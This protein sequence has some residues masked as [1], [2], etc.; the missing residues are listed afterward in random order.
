MGMTC[1]LELE[2]NTEREP[3]HHVCTSSSTSVE[4]REVQKEIRREADGPI[5]GEIDPHSD[6]N[7]P[8]RIVPE[9][10]R[11]DETK[12]ALKGQLEAVVG[13]RNIDPVLSLPGKPDLV[14]VPRKAELQQ[15][16]Q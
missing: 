11:M 7:E 16:T 10:I 15:G 8:G 6:R 1:L 3:W 2:T 9:K 12:T 5:Y 14:H 4:V 13:I